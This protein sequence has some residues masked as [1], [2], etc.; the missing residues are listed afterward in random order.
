MTT[1][2]LENIKSLLSNRLTLP[3]PGIEAHKKMAPPQRFPEDNPYQPNENTRIGCVLLLLFP[4]EQGDL[5]FPLMVRPDYGGTHS[6]QVSLPGGKHELED[7]DLMHTALREMEEEMGVTITREQVVGQMTTVYIPPSNFLVHPFIAIIEEEPKFVPS[8]NEVA[9]LFCVNVE[10]L[11]QDYN[12]LTKPLKFKGKD[13]IVP[14]Y[15][16]DSNMVWGATAMML[17]EFACIWEDI[18]V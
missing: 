14:F 17:S 9:K 12:R 8:P 10:E 5:Y 1:I 16:L 4:N 18:S 15:Q 3:L 13:V 7:E 2:D 11:Q 6:G